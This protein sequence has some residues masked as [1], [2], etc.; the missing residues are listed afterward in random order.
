MKSMKQIKQQAQAGFTLIELMIVVAIIGI[1][2]AV[3]IPAY[4]D[5]T[6]KAKVG[7]ILG[8]TDGLKSA[9]I[10]CVNEA[11]GVSSNCV[12]G[13]MDASG[14]PNGVPEFQKTKEVLSAV[15]VG[16]ADGSTDLLTVTTQA[17][18]GDGISSKAIT[19]KPNYYVGGDKTKRAA[20]VTWTVDASAFT[21]GVGKAAAEK[22]NPPA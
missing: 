6:I 9:I 11:G 20:N 22:N 7:S 2:A 19:F 13:G 3:A 21:S 18:L 12:P 10:T 16:S 15:F 17:N 5:Y 14:N 4:S 1:L 8:Q